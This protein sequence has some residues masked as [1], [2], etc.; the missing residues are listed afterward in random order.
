MLTA[1]HCLCPTPGN[2][3]EV[4]SFY[5]GRHGS[6]ARWVSEGIKIRVHN[7]WFS[8]GDDSNDLGV[9]F[10][11][12]KLGNETGWA[13]LEVLSDQQHENRYVRVTGY[14]YERQEDLSPYMYTMQ[15]LIKVIKPSKIYY[16]IDTSGGQSGSGVCVEDGN[17]I[18]RCIA[19]HVTGCPV[20]GNGAVRI[21][22]EKIS[23]ISQ[24]LNDHN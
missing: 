1:G 12:H 9:L 19:V 10:L 17:N 24:W 5:P 20:E 2:P 23:L 14:P 3:A 18:P 4:V 22:N 7:N 6:F 16:D 13:T 8:Y 11:E 21:N 15:G